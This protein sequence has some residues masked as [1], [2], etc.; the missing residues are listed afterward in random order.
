M[1]ID[2]LASQ[3]HYIDHI[4]PIWD[5]LPGE[6]RMGN[7]YVPEDL[8]DYT[9][10][11]I[12][13]GLYIHGYERNSPATFGI[14]PILVCAY[15][16]LLYCK[17]INPERNVIVMEHGVGHTFHTAAYPDGAGKRDMASLFLAPNEYTAEKIRAVRNT[18]V[19]VIGTPKMDEI[20]QTFNPRRTL[21]RSY[22]SPPTIAVGFHWGSKRNRP[23]ESGSAFEYYKQ[24]LPQLSTQYKLIAYGHPLA[25]E[26][27]KP[28]YESIGIEYVETLVEV[29]H[30]ASILINDLSSAMYEFLL[31]GSPVIVLNAPWFRK[32]VE[33]GIRF[34]DYSDIGIHV[35]S[36]EA[37]ASVIQYTLDNYSTVRK[38]ERE[39]TIEDLYPFAGRASIKAAAV[40]VKYLEEHDE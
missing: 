2:F 30:R 18:K 8:K 23:P 32:T 7:F 16:D 13:N 40:L 20:V 1:Q 26:V 19:E 6:H 36:P 37:L 38:E 15:G 24:I 17:K 22:F 29:F 3:K 14:N 31:T 28:F 25:R 10:S 4:A 27:Y 12:R 35:D 11:K 34:W 5:A 33:H 9:H 21:S 39:K